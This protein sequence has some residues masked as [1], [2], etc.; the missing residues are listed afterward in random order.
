[1][2]WVDSPKPVLV[3]TGFR[4]EFKILFDGC[5]KMIDQLFSKSEDLGDML[6]FL[7]GVVVQAHGMSVQGMW[8]TYIG[9]NR[10]Y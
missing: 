9:S 1:M 6:R 10:I 5:R 7:P 4:A 8:P 2:T 3:K